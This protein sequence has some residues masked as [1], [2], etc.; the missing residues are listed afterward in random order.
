MSEVIVY[1]VPG[2]P[3]VRSALLGF[4][5]KGA[6][7]RLHAL[8]L[9]EE[10]TPAHLARHP[11]G[12]VPTIDHDGFALY[13]T[14][15][16]IRYVDAAFA[17]PALQPR[18]AQA[19]ARMNQLIGIV[20]WYFFH[21]VTAVIGFNRLL[22]PLLGI[23][24]DEAAVTAAIPNAK[25][26]LDVL[27]RFKG[28]NRFMVGSDISIADLMLAAQLATFMQTPEGQHLLSGRALE[29]WLAMMNE[30]PST[31]GNDIRA[32]AGA[33]ASGR[34]MPAPLR[35]PRSASSITAWVYFFFAPVLFST[36][37]TVL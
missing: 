24:T 25:N 2:S 31:A 6:P 35:H 1:G 8:G 7:Y 22:A 14:Q 23:T 32:P 33:H 16:I 19:S 27:E 28:N 36:V 29:D 4:E 11:F 10:K 5:E 26:C 18:D 15:A 13:D 12:R 9:G 20:D 34:M 17:G 30:R 3:Y 21:Q 37:I